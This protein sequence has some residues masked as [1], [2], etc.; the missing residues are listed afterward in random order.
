MRRRTFIAALGGAAA[1]PMV[2]RAQQDRMRLIGVLMGF[3]DDADSQI[4]LAAFRQRL[5]ALGWSEGNNLR[6]E[7]RWTAGDINLATALAKELVALQPE[8]ILAFTTHATE[9]LQ[10]ETQSIPVVF[11]SV[12]DPIGSGFVKS[13]SHP[14]SNVTGFVNLE[15]SMAEKWLELLKEIAPRTTHVTVILNP[16][17]AS[18]ANYY[19]GPL[20]AVAPKLGVTVL[21]TPVQTEADI[22]TALSKIAHNSSSGVVIMLDS[23]MFVH[24][25][26]I[27]DL[28][29]RHNI[30]AIN[31]FTEMTV[32][33]GLIS[34]SGN[35]PD[36]FNRA[37]AYID[38]IL[39]GAKPSELPV[40]APT[41]FNLVINLKTAAALGLT[42]PPALLAT[43][44]EV[45]E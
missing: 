12:P 34:Y 27:I 33:G 18:F 37:A 3:A 10:R 8:A 25:K 29:A 24:R 9:A 26:L 22:E 1:W 16:Q 5:A 6:I 15:A 42:V 20:Q 40:Q 11:V 4:R 45:I 28:T 13:L 32:E 7:L 41:K 17:T 19:L 38:R 31:P 43:A 36:L 44:D 30:P 39:R 2:V 23:F 35:G 14:E 21:P